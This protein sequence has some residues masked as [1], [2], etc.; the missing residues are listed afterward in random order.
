[1]NLEIKDQLFLVGGASGGLGRAIAE[2]LL[3]E[4]AKVLA[5]SR[6]EDK[7]QAFQTSYPDQLEYLAADL[8]Q[9]ESLPL[10]LDA[11]GDR[12]LSGA[13]I[14]AGG[15]PAMPVM[16]TTLPD[17]DEAYRTVVRWKIALTQALVPKMIEKGYGRMLYIESVTVKQPK[18]NLV[19]SN[20]MRMAVVGYVKTLS[21]EI[22]NTGVTL[23]I[24]GPSFHATERLDN[25]VR[26][27]SELKGISEAEVRASIIQQ[28]KVGF[29]GRPDDFASLAV[30]FLSPVSRYI[31]GQTISVDGGNVLGSMG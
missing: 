4:G 7:L 25:L 13:V 16:Q 20:S 17:W 8:T 12:L 6:S 26:K 27:N 22:A 21:Q 3:A 29:I 15:P 11:I 9:S 30:W 14:N 28:A 18:E 5:V 1:M 24:L 10:L 23:N 31:T 19:L 2:T